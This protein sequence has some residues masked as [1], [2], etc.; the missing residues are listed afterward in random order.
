MIVADN[1]K[2][3]FPLKLKGIISCFPA[4]KPTQEHVQ[5]FEQIHLMGTEHWEPSPEELP[6]PTRTVSAST[7]NVPKPDLEEVE[8]KLLE[9][10]H[11]RDSG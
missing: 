11:S 7:S 6:R 5:N 2:V 1:L 8:A 10:D 4:R 9:K 3:T